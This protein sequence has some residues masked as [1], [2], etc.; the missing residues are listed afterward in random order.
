MLITEDQKWELL[1]A[2]IG[3]CNEDPD[4]LENRLEE[5]IEIKGDEL[6]SSYISE[7]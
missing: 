1:H 4:F 7:D 5:L 3:Y 2:L 6:Y